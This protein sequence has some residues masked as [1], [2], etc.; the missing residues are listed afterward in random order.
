MKERYLEVTY[1]S[2]KPIVG[3]LH[4]PRANGVKSARTEEMVPGL[5]VDFSIDGRPIGL[6]VTAP[7]K[8]TLHQRR[9]DGSGP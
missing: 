1:R 3:Y 7:T 4:L 5:L 2:G 8:V 6:E 9:T